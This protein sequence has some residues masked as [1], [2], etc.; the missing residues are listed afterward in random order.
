MIGLFCGEIALFITVMTGLLHTQ[1]RYWGLL[2]R[3][4]ALLRDFT[5]V[6]TACHKTYP[7]G[8]VKAMKCLLWLSHVTQMN[9]SCH[10]NERVMSHI[11][12]VTRTPHMCIRS[13]DMGLLC[14]EKGLFPRNIGLFCRE[15]GLF[16]VDIRLLWGEMELFCKYIRLFCKNTAFFEVWSIIEI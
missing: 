4:R 3:D 7:Y 13:G 14:G 2:W 16:C 9:G 8:G 12:R 15:I 1:W 6:N 5:N 11:S 10:T